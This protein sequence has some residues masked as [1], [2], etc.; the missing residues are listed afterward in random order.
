MLRWIS[1]G[2]IIAFGAG[3][4]IVM[5]SRLFYYPQDPKVIISGIAGH[6]L[7]PLSFGAIAAWV[8]GEFKLGSDGAFHRRLNWFA[9]LLWFLYLL[10]GAAPV[11]WR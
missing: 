2:L 8:L 4:G 10:W 5:Y 3:V 1:S 6:A 7:G 9:I 11:L